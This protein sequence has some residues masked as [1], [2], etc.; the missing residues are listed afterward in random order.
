MLLI[1]CFAWTRIAVFL[2]L[3]IWAQEAYCR[4]T[5]NE[6]SQ[7]YVHFKQRWNEIPNSCILAD[8]LLPAWPCGRKLGLLTSSVKQMTVEPPVHTCSNN[9]FFWEN[10]NFQYA[11]HVQIRL[12]PIQGLEQRTGWNENEQW[13]LHPLGLCKCSH[14]PADPSG[15]RLLPPLRYWPQMITRE[16]SNSAHHRSLVTFSTLESGYCYYL[17][18]CQSQ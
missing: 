7:K 17:N 15:P 3:F 8:D 5:G 1:K 2:V 12:Q 4:L 18:S 13:P 14:L 10:I 16:H 6:S 11:Q 9:S